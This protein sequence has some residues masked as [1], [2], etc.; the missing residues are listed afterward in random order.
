MIPSPYN[1]MININ[2]NGMIRWRI[3]D[4]HLLLSQQPNSPNS[5]LVIESP[6]FHIGDHQWQLILE[7]SPSQHSCSLRLQPYRGTLSTTKSTR[8]SHRRRF[9][10][11]ANEP[12][13]LVHGQQRPIVEYGLRLFRHDDPSIH[14]F[15]RSS[16]GS[17]DI[18]DVM[19]METNDMRE[20][21]TSPSTLLSKLASHGNI[22]GNPNG[23]GKEKVKAT[24]ASDDDDQVDSTQNKAL[25][26]ACHA[27]VL[28]VD[29]PFVSF[30]NSPI[31]IINSGSTLKSSK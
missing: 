1:C 30:N 25:V 17:N 9:S 15:T 22:N 26:L 12:S 10:N 28:F 19:V 24:E 5:S 31:T 20:L 6:I 16:N 3:N 29:S 21:K 11:N 4:Y 18:I 27:R 2:N 14:T 23:K 13:V 8:R 7:L